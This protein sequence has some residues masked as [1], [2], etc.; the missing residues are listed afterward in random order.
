VRKAKERER[1]AESTT[2][3]EREREKERMRKRVSEQASVCARKSERER[4]IE[5]N[6]V[7]RA[8]MPPFAREPIEIE[9]ES[10][11]D[12]DKREIARKRVNNEVGERERGGCVGKEEFLQ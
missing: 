1:E 10:K 12:G 9:R 3:R 5:S 7:D 4:E 6:H 2:E 8:R 11:R